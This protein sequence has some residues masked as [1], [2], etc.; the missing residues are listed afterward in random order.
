GI[1][2]HS[3]RAHILFV[4]EA[5]SR[6]RPKAV[7]VMAGIN[8]L[9][10]TLNDEARKLGSPA[11]QTGWK[12]SILGN[13]RVVQVLFLWKIILFDDVVV[14]NR[15][16]NANFAPEPLLQEMELPHDIRLL[17]PTIEEY[18]KNVRTIIADLKRMNVRPIFITQPLLFDDSEKWMS[19]VGWEYAVGGKR[20]KLSAATYSKLLDVFNQDLIQ[21]CHSDSV[22][23]FDL[24]SQIPHSTDLFYDVMH[25]SE[26]GAELV[27]GKIA[28]HINDNYLKL[29]KD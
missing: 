12:Y 27:A 9:G 26:K 14:L 18:K 24:A 1:S 19:V 3:T 11:E 23:V 2:G 6:I 20:G 5:I 10:Y 15:S 28:Q 7:V 25:F 16:E 4:R 21:T 8:D 17:L 22:D 29:R 13:S